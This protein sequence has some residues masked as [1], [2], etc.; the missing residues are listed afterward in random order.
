MPQR[1]ATAAA[2]GEVHDEPVFDGRGAEDQ[3]MTS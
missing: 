3:C 1:T 2:D